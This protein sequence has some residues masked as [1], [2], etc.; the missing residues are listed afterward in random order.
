MRVLMLHVKM[1]RSR[2]EASALW[3]N[4]GIRGEFRVND[5]PYWFGLAISAAE[6][7]MV[8]WCERFE[9]DASTAFW[10]GHSKRK[11]EPKCPMRSQLPGPLDGP[12]I[13][14]R[15]RGGATVDGVGHGREDEGSPLRLSDD[16]DKGVDI[17]LPDRVGC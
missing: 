8:R 3:H 7:N 9:F 16:K 1:G 11:R 2:Q 6:N 15:V 12:L 14:S 10:T 17:A 4:T 13:C 5:H